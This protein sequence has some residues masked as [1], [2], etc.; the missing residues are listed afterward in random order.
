M[1]ILYTLVARGSVVLAE[2][3]GTPTNASTVARQ[4]L[5]KTP[6]NNDM[7]V[8]YSQDR[9]IFHVKRTDGLTVLCMADDVAGRRIPFAFLEDIHQRFVR[10]YGRAVL[11]AQAYGMN[12]EFSRVLSQQM[13]YYSN[14]PNADRINRLKGEMG[15]VRTVMIENIDKVLDRG[16][17]LELLVDKTATMQTNTL[18]FRKQTR[19]FRSTVWWRNVKLT[20][21]LILLILVIAYVVSAFVCHGLTLPSCL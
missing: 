13:E 10:T 9:Y 7:N 17:R 11:S 15:Q 18:R 8:S 3:S 14:D 2:F 5:E 12:D 21:V 20:I 1:A 16:D 4:I 6:G 19:R